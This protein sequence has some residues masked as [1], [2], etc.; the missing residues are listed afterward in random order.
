MMLEAGNLAY[1]QMRSVRRD[2]CHSLLEIVFPSNFFIH[3]FINQEVVFVVHTR[4]ITWN[5]IDVA[6]NNE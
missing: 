2:N 1:T 5:L 3:C 6:L 4:T